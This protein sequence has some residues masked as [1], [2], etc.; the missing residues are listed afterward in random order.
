[1]LKLEAELRV[2]VYPQGSIGSAVWDLLEAS[3]ASAANLPHNEPRHLL[4]YAFPDVA[5]VLVNA[6]ELW[7]A[8]DI[9]L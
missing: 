4:N 7:K 5:V 9:E 3:V 2:R 6:I 8:G 1:M